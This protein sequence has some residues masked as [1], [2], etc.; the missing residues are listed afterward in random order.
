LLSVEAYWLD[1]L[2]TKNNSIRLLGKNYASKWSKMDKNNQTIAFLPSV[3]ILVV[4]MVIDG[5]CRSILT[6]LSGYKKN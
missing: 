2:D 5:V 3:P 6:R 4:K 1:W